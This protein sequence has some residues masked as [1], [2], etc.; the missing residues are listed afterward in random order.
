MDH[1]PF[2][3]NK[4]KKMAMEIDLTPSQKLNQF[5]DYQIPQLQ[6]SNSIMH[7]NNDYIDEGSYKSNEIED[8]K[9]VISRLI[10]KTSYEG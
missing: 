4:Y 1:S 5:K 9:N 3:E 8:S 10:T 2:P 7:H 6:K